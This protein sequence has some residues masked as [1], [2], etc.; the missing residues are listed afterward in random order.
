MEHG[1]VNPWVKINLARDRIFP[2]EICDIMNGQIV[3]CQ[4]DLNTDSKQIGKQ[5]NK[6]LSQPV[7]RQACKQKSY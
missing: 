4:V 5:I 1:G 3:A 7:T 6:S 2:L